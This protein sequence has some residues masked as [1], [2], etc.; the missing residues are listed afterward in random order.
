MYKR[1]NLAI[2]TTASFQR[3]DRFAEVLALRRTAAAIDNAFIH[4]VHNSRLLTSSTPRRASVSAPT[5]LIHPNQSLWR[6]LAARQ[7]DRVTGDYRTLTLPGAKNL[8]HI[9]NPGAFVDAIAEFAGGL[10]DHAALRV[11]RRGV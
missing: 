4:S 1:Q 2:N 10:T 7:R 8:P 5:L 3:S 6:R 11:G 9:E